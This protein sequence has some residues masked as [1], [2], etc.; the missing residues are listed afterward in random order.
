M[1][2]NLNC[3]VVTFQCGKVAIP[4]G[5]SLL[6]R[7]FV[8]RMVSHRGGRETRVTGDEAQGTMG[9]VKTGG[10]RFLLPTFLCAQIF[11]EREREKRLGTRQPRDPSLLQVPLPF[12]GVKPKNDG[13]SLLL[14]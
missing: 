8:F 6:L 9:R 2:D 3:T 12:K 11:I 10:A 4:A 1:L 5:I 13:R 7:R 14:N